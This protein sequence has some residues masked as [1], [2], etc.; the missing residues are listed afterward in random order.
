MDDGEA[1][2]SPVNRFDH[3][4]VLLAHLVHAQ[5]LGSLQT[6]DRGQKYGHLRVLRAL[7]CPGVLVESGFLSHDAEA[8]KIATPEYRQQIATALAD[9]IKDYAAAI[10]SARARAAQEAAGALPPR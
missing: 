5:V 6:V 8:R 2:A 4:S 7:N 9:G 1:Q 3:L 10:E